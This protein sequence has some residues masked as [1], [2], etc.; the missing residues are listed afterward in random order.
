MNAKDEARE[1]L[2]K[3]LWEVYRRPSR[4]NVL[5]AQECAIAYAA[6]CVAEARASLVEALEETAAEEVTPIDAMTEECLRETLRF[7]MGRAA[8]A[9]AAKETP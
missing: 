8:D 5:T 7:K 2:R 3:S 6:L 4:A 9:L 1:A